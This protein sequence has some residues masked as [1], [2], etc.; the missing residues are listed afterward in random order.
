MY[1]S[2]RQRRVGVASYCKQI[3][4]NKTLAALAQ[5]CANSKG[6]FQT[7]RPR[8]HAP[9]ADRC[10]AARAKTLNC[11]CNTIQSEPNSKAARIYIY[12]KNCFAMLRK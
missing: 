3:K 2:C 6:L 1:F 7:S 10:C 5:F 4:P 8:R 12:K 9:L 11:K